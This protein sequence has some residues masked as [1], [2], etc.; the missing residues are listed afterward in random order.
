MLQPDTD[1]DK[2]GL[3][4]RMHIPHLGFVTSVGSLSSLRLS[5]ALS[6]PKYSMVPLA[7]PAYPT[8]V[9]DSSVP[10]VVGNERYVTQESAR[11]FDMPLTY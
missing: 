8:E 7:P 2:G 10:T 3:F 9:R 4:Q 11:P 6:V 1:Q 5:R